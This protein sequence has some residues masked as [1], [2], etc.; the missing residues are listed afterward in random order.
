MLSELEPRKKA[1]FAILEKICVFSDV[2]QC[3]VI[4]NRCDSKQV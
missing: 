3:G 2:G 4:Q 1:R